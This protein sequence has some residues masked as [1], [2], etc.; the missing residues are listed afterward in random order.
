MKKIK[1][2]KFMKD[3]RL[4][5]YLVT[6]FVLSVFLLSAAGCSEKVDK[7][8]GLVVS[9][10]IKMTSNDTVTPYYRDVIV[11]AY[12]ADTIN[13]RVEN[14]RDARDGVLKN[15]NTGE[16]KAPEFVSHLNAD[17]H[18][19]LGVL[20]SGNVVLVACDL[21]GHTDLKSEMYAYR[22]IEL[23]PGLSNMRIALVFAPYE[24]KSRFVS[25]KWTMCNDNPPPEPGPEPEPGEPG[26]GDGED[27]GDEGENGGDGNGGEGGE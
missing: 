17:L 20:P 23:V 12:Y 11:Y 3:G 7:E 25:N 4:S 14:Y 15:I 19:E 6:A 10:W 26:D 13:W 1:T 21:Y 24:T 8:T 5:A 27:G 22:H 2:C 16:T 18:Q 9:S